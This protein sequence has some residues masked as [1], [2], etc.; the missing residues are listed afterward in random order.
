MTDED[1]LNVKRDII[2]RI[3]P[4]RVERLPNSGFGAYIDAAEAL[5]LRCLEDKTE[6]EEFG[7]DWDIVEE[8]PARVGALRSCQVLW[9]KAGRDND[10]AH[11]RLNRAFRQAHRLKKD[12][13]CQFRSAYREDKV[14]SGELKKIFDKRSINKVTNG[15]LGKLV[16]FGVVNPEPLVKT[17]FDMSLLDRGSRLTAKIPAL[18]DT[19]AAKRLKYMEISNLRDQAYTYLKEAMDIVLEFG[20]TAFRDNEKRLHGYTR[21]CATRKYSRRSPYREPTPEAAAVAI[22]ANERARAAGQK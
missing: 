11:N 6:L 2:K 14:L 3:T 9:L 22:T 19:A 8:I 21:K 17:G 18:L 20:Q 1:Y 10:E 4:D 16:V 15:E 12:L 5:Y 7:L 13:V